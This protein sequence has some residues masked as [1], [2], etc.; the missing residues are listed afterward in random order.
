M[1]KYGMVFPQT[2]IGADPA[3]VRRYAEVTEALGYHYLLAFDHVIGANPEKPG[4]WQGGSYTVESMFHEPFVLFGYLA[5]ITQ[6]LAFATGILILPQRQTVLVA[7]QAAQVDILCGGRLRLGIGVGWNPLEYEALGMAFETRGKRQTEQVAL[8]RKLWTQRL[9][10]FEG[11]FDRIPDGGLNPLPVQQPIP[12]W[13]GGMSDAALRR[14]AQMGDGWMPN[15]ADPDVLTG[16]LA[17]L[18]DYM[19]AAGR[20]AGSPLGLDVRIDMRRYGP[21]TWPALLDRYAELGVTHVCLNAM[22]QGF[23][24]NDHLETASQFR[25]MWAVS[26]T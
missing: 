23:D 19:G 25:A 7:K 4:P 17:K 1:M 24:L 13:F 5:G 16:M 22:G 10:E 11:E 12:I 14:T 18:R 26:S 2:E 20:D 21:E 6:H 15:T 3:G 9:V 8:L